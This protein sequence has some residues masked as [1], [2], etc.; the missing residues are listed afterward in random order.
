MDHAVVQSFKRQMEIL[1]KIQN[2]KPRD[3]RT[4]IFGG[5]ALSNFLSM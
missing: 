5:A 2:L 4:D 3:L 1:N